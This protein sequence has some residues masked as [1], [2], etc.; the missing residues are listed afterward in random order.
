MVDKNLFLYDMAVVAIFKNEGKY[1][2]E[3]LDYHLLAGVEHFYLYNNDSSD[4]YAEILAPYVEKNL[5]TLI[6]FPGNAMQHPAYNDAVEKY[7]FDC[8]YM[9]FIDLDEFIFPKTNRSIVEVVDEILAGDARAQALGISWHIFGS[10]GQEKADYSVGVLERFTRR[11][12]DKWENF[13]Q[14]DSKNAL[15]I[16]NMYVKLV[17]NPRSLKVLQGPHVGVH[18]GENY[19]VNESGEKI[20]D[21]SNENMSANKIALNHY[22]LKSWEEYLLK[23]ARGYACDTS[24]P[25]S[26][27][28]FKI[29]DRNEVFDDGILNYRV[30]RAD[31]FFLE[32]DA[33]KI[34]R[35]EKALIETLTQC[36][37]INP[38]PNF[39][40]GKL[41]TFLTCRALAELLGT[42]IGNK[43]A[44][45]YALIWIYQSFVQ[46][47]LFT[48]AELQLF[49]SA[50]P[51][52]LARPFPVCKLINK[53]A[54]EKI[55]PLIYN[56]LKK[57]KEWSGFYDF[58]YIQRLLDLR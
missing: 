47:N 57:A 12:P 58:R 30:A 20:T 17:A 39:F 5:V 32:S 34:R 48:Y 6:D 42:K 45:E 3:W 38:P 4:D 18:F 21:Y 43:T 37:P 51:E 41:E 23:Q 1:L 53:I 24:N 44:E 40:A 10:N 22:N 27:F 7:R 35:A 36:S 15:R 9:A 16:G 55:F 2:R 29:H 50:L 11:A 49:I 33:D 14:L 25:Y 31:K 8:R 54:Q 56:D 19:T 28:Y 13:M 46:K 52:I 26:D